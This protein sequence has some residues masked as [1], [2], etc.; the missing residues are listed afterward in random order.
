M[1]Q[2]FKC[3][4]CGESIIYRKTKNG[5]SMPCEV[6]PVYYIEI[7]YERETYKKSDKVLT[8]SGRLISVFTNGITKENYEGVGFIPHFA[9]C[10]R[11][12]QKKSPA[13]T[14]VTQKST[15]RNNTP[16]TNYEQTSLFP[17][18]QAK[19]INPSLN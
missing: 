1:P 16:T 11:R 5:K 13:K 14:I 18:P 10:E 7:P 8:A 19:Y 15:V 12:M 17:E 4:T 9:E 6:N 2:I 3:K